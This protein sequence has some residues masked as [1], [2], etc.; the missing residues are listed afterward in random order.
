[1][2]RNIGSNDKVEI[3]FSQNIFSGSFYNILGFYILESSGTFWDLHFEF[4][5]LISPVNTSFI[6][7]I[8]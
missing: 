4:L 3:K 8:G 2:F 7:G 1:M 6:G 5:G